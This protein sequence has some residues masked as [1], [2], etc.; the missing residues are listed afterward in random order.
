MNK[1]NNDIIAI[2]DDML[3]DRREVHTVGKKVTV[4]EPL[5]EYWRECV[6]LFLRYA[7]IGGSTAISTVHARLAL[8]VLKEIKGKI[9]IGGTENE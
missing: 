7:V 5:D 6:C 8:K 4:I 9:E 2:L 3:R 1:D